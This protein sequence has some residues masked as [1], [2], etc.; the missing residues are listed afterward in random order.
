MGNNKYKL[1]IISL[2][3]N[4]KATDI[5]EY[6][7]AN[8]GISDE[9]KQKSL[10]YDTPSIILETDSFE[11]ASRVHYQLEQL[12]AHAEIKK[13]YL[14]TAERLKRNDVQA[15]SEKKINL[16]SVILLA[17]LLS[18]LG[19]AAVYYYKNAQSNWRSQKGSDDNISDRVE[20]DRD[21]GFEPTVIAFPEEKGATFEL[22][23]E[24]VGAL[25]VIG[26]YIDDKNYRKAY[27]PLLEYLDENPDD[28][29]AI[30]AIK[31]VS[32]NLA[33]E[34][35]ER[36][37]LKD[38][39]QY[40][41]KAL[42]Y[43]PKD[44]QL[45][46]QAGTFYYAEKNY[47]K[48]LSFLN[49]AVGEGSDDPD[50]H[51]LLARLYY[52]HGDN[53]TKARDLLTKA[54]ELDPKRDD[55]REFLDKINKE[56]SIE[57]QFQAADNEHFIVKY[58][59]IE[60][61]DAAYTVLYVLDDAY[62]SIGYDL[63]EYPKDPMIV[64]LYTNQQFADVTNAPP[65]AGGIFDGRI[66]LPAANLP[67]REDANLRRLL[68]HEYTHVVIHRITNGHCP[69]WLNE[70]IAQYMQVR[71]GGGADPWLRTSMLQ[72]NRSIPSLSA[73]NAPFI[74]LDQDDALRAYVTSYFA[75]Q[76]F[77]GEYGLTDV[78]RVLDLIGKGVKFGQALTEI[79]GAQY[80]DFEKRF[81]QYLSEQ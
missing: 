78:S 67:D 77:V 81:H 4:A 23:L 33:R 74:N 31:F 18:I 57:G 37:N 7:A 3:S 38:A 69:V 27:D 51:Y 59:G 1:Y 46:A 44:V 36:R 40:M 11:E 64:I 15:N 39:I 63:G 30:K 75:V 80:E 60:D 21:D 35:F 53:L 8:L 42:E 22:S 45:L 16:S 71:A 55:I 48:A 24:N 49:K 68:Y 61:R 76:Y 17:I 72:G 19:A 28:K 56:Q 13:P 52:F 65:W 2:R 20:E 5:C 26:K 32:F 54:L 73:L 43:L 70:G 14:G 25:K 41:E 47:D 6:L 79:T 12:G 58:Q 9:F 34:S 29:E 66:R 50:V 62:S 10:I